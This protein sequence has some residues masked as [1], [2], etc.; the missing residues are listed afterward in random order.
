MRFSLAPQAVF[1]ARTVKY[2]LY[3]QAGSVV[4]MMSAPRAD[5][6]AVWTS[7]WGY[8]T[9]PHLRPGDAQPE[10]FGSWGGLGGGVLTLSWIGPHE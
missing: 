7:S 3:I 1:P 2:T 5:T 6:L 8:R 9:C 10:S 4:I